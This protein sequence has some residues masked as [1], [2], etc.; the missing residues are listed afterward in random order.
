MVVS[1]QRCHDEKE[2]L[3]PQLGRQDTLKYT[4]AHPSSSSVASCHPQ[5]E[6]SPP[7]TKVTIPL[8]RP[9][10][11][12]V[13]YTDLEL[14][15]LGL[16]VYLSH[17]AIFCYLLVGDNDCSHLIRLYS[18][19]GTVLKNL[20]AHPTVSMNT[21]YVSFVMWIVT[22][23][24]TT[25]DNTQECK[26]ER[27]HKCVWFIQEATTWEKANP[28]PR[29]NSKDPALPLKFLKEESFREVTRAF[30]ILHSLQAPSDW[31]VV[32]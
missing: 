32:S 9:L 10:C 26:S 15:G 23:E 17:W 29:N 12:V 7:L 18:D 31:L 8:Y 13:R 4:K 14:D 22:T 27:T 28:Y 6:G 16:H 1:V 30:I 20:H 3:T 2:C 24:L 25:E 11:M 21:C 19:A 5:M